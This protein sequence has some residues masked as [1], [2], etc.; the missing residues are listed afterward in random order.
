MCVYICDHHESMI[1]GKGTKKNKREG[2]ASRSSDTTRGESEEE[3]GEAGGEQIEQI[4]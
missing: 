2:I 4:Q 3:R 1:T